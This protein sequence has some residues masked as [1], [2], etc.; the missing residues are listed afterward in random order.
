MFAQFPGLVAQSVTYPFEVVRRRMQ[1]EGIISREVGTIAALTSN[2]V[3]STS[4][5]AASFASSTILKEELTMASCVRDIV[6]KQG[7]SDFRVCKFFII[8]LI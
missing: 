1:T 5:G 7:V 6:S 4:N 2:N 3:Q 8:A